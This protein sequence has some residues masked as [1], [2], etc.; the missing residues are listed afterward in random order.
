MES[1]PTTVL[2]RVIFLPRSCSQQMLTP[3]KAL[4]P[5][6]ASLVTNGCFL[7]GFQVQSAGRES[8]NM[9]T[10]VIP[11]VVSHE[12]KLKTIFLTK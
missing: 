11:G 10:R 8:P 6:L 2:V 4:A 12:E 5:I 1:V 9:A 7:L 3:N